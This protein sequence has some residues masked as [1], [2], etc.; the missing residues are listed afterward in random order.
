MSVRT[1]SP[2]SRAAGRALVLVA[3]GVSLAGCGL[4]GPGAQPV[5]TRSREVSE[6]QAERLLDGMREVLGE[7]RPVALD[8]QIRMFDGC[9][10]GWRIAAEDEPYRLAIGMR[11]AVTSEVLPARVRG[12]RDALAARGLRVGD[13]RESRPAAGQSMSE[14]WFTAELTTGDR[15]DRYTLEVRVGDDTGAGDGKTTVLLTTVSACLEPG[16]APAGSP[17]PSSSPAPSRVPVS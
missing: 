1:A 16:E 5:G 4:L 12:L 15:Q 11:V 9:S 6:Q 13:Y 3:V 2:R 10:D 17:S 7:G 8:G 14:P